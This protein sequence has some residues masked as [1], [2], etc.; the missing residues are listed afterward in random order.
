MQHPSA[1]VD[2]P[3]FS[4]RDGF[5]CRVQFEDFWSVPRAAR[6]KFGQLAKKRSAT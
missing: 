5:G 6:M 3:R 2:W 1:I 4:R